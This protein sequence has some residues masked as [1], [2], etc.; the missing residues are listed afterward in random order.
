[1]HH[2]SMFTSWLFICFLFTAKQVVY[3]GHFTNCNDKKKMHWL[4]Q[5]D[6]IQIYKP[7]ACNIVW[8]WRMTKAQVR[9]KTLSADR[10]RERKI[11]RG[12]RGRRRSNLEEWNR[13]LGTE[14]CRRNRQEQRQW[15]KARLGEWWRDY[16]REKE[17]GVGKMGN[18]KQSQAVVLV[19]GRDRWLARK[20]I[21]GVLSHLF[22]RELLV[23]LKRFAT[24]RLSTRIWSLINNVQ[25]RYWT[26]TLSDQS[27]FVNSAAWRVEGL[28]SHWSRETEEKKNRIMEVVLIFCMIS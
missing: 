14:N 1:M 23:I 17:V 21:W 7:S 25:K 6:Y 16:C 26:P 13:T 4:V 3:I 22:L 9:K 28:E 19:C 15:E 2:C 18:W 27:C 12:G 8:L 20:K 5:L 11:N 10:N 24:F